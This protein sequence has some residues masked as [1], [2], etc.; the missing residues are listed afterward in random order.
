VILRLGPDPGHARL[1]TVLV[2]GR[3]QDDAIIRDLAARVHACDVAH[4][5]LVTPQRSWYPG[6]YFDPLATLEPHLG[7]ALDAVDRAIAA[8]GAPDAQIVLAGFSQGA[9]LIA[10]HLARRGPRPY[11]G[12]AILTGCLP[13]APEERARPAVAVGLPV[14]VTCAREDAWIAV[15]D[16]RDTARRF[17]AAGAAASFIELPDS[18]HHISDAAVAQLQALLR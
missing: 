16:A 10:E 5:L 2:H 9:C 1:T 14:L 12:A 13:G 15:D 11:A 17:A 4:V 18:E 7:S 3:D 6:R 8:T